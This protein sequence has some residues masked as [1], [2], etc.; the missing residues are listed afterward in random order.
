ML[1]VALAAAKVQLC[2][3]LVFRAR[4]REELVEALWPDRSLLA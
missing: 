3:K 1:G 2:R 4:T